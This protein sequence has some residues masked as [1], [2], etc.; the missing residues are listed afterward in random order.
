MV[1]VV[2]R[3]SVAQSLRRASPGPHWSGLA[4]FDQVSQIPDGKGPVSHKS[5]TAGLGLRVS[6]PSDSTVRAKTDEST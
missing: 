1:A 3:R 5:D 4:T 2:R 6:E